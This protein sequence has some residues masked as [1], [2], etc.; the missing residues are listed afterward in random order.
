MAQLVQLKRSS[1]PGNVPSTGQLDEGEIA[2]NTGDGRVFIK[3][4]DDS[5]QHLV[6][7]D[8]QTTGSIEITG[9][10][11][12]SASSTGS[13]GKVESN[14]LSVFDR[15]DS[16]STLANSTGV[17]EI[18]TYGTLTFSTAAGELLYMGTAGKW[19]HADSDALT[20]G[21]YQL[22]GLAMGTTVADGILLRGHMN[23][24]S[25]ILA[26][27]DQGLAVYV[28][29]TDGNMDTVAPTTSGHFVR[30]VGYCTDTANVMYFNPGTT[31]VEIA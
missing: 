22:L 3:K 13:F 4:D 23:V 29:S 19:Y 15:I 25:G 2:I 9:N 31:W 16:I 8:S 5:I 11:S 10:I 27:W 1:T 24:S 30:V 14:T 20:T 18:V 17:G 26:H 6:T 12:G 7:T 21:A 28:T